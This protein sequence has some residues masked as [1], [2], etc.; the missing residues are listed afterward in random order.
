VIA[1]DWWILDT[2]SDDAT[3]TY[4]DERRV[5]IAAVVPDVGIGG[6]FE[7]HYDMG[8]DW[9]HRIVAEA[10]PPAWLQYELRLP[11][12]T[13]GENACPPEDLGGTYGYDQFRESIR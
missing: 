10:T 12:C 13:A 3:S 6:S 11:A 1:P 2:K 8:D 9:Q 7:Y 5:S 4:E